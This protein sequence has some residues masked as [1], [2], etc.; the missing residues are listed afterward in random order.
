MK[1]WVPPPPPPPLFIPTAFLSPTCRVMSNVAQYMTVFMANL[2]TDAGS[3][4]DC[5]AD[6]HSLCNNIACA[7]PSTGQ[8][9]NYSFQACESPT[10]FSTSHGFSDGSLVKGSYNKSQQILLFGKYEAHLTL[11]S[12][13]EGLVQFKVRLSGCQ[14]SVQHGHTEHI[15][16]FRERMH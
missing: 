10:S 13:S 9:F 7:E 4:L 5:F 11:N 6:R 14:A 16:Y 3:T 2:T 12:L 8:H 15:V 1:L